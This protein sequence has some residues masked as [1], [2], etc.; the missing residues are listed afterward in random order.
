MPH[1]T[2]ISDIY[3]NEGFDPLALAAD[4]SKVLR[5]DRIDLADLRR[6]GPLLRFHA[7]RDGIEIFSRSSE[8]TAEFRIAA[9]TFW[10]DAGPIIDRAYEAVLDSLGDP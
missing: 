1:P 4:L 10:C 6:A 3:P 5:T 7:A 9:A 8:V 2:G